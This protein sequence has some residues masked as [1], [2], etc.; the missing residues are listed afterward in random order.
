MKPL[1]WIIWG[2]HR[3]LTFLSDGAKRLGHILY[4]YRIVVVGLF[5]LF[6]V[7][8]LA[9][10]GQDLLLNLN[11]EW[12]GPI[13]FLVTLVVLASLNWHLPKYFTDQA[14]K[15]TQTRK[16][17]TRMFV[18][19]PEIAGQKH[20]GERNSARMMG[21][22]T[23]LIPAC[24]IWNAMQQ[25]RIKFIL[26]F[27]NPYLLLFVS[28]VIFA[29]AFRAQ[30]IGNLWQK[31]PRATSVLIT[32]ISFIFLFIIAALPFSAQLSAP[33]FLVFMVL[34]LYLLAI[35][36]SLFVA[37]RKHI[38]SGPIGWISR[39]IVTIVITLGI[40]F[41]V[42]FIVMNIAPMMMMHI[43]RYITFGV[44]LTGVIFYS[45]V[46]TM[47]ALLSRLWKINLILIMMVAG[48]VLQIS[49]NNNFHNIRMLTGNSRQP[50]SGLISK[51]SLP[52]LDS[53]LEGWLQHR[54]D[55]IL[56]WNA[57]NAR[58][59]R[60]EKYPVFLVN[61]YGGGIRAAAWTSMVIGY[62]DEV[63]RQNYGKAFQHHVLAYSAVSG[64]AIGAAMMCAQRYQYGD[65]QVMTADR[66]YSLY[67][68]DYLTPV[69]IGMQG[70]DIWFAPFRSD[71]I[72]DRA[73]FQE[74]TWERHLAL[75]S[76]TF[77]SSYFGMWYD[78]TATNAFEVPLLFSNTYNADDGKKG[79]LAPV[80]L[81]KNEFP[82]A[83][84][85]NDLY[86]LDGTDTIDENLR[87][88]TAAFLSAR[89]PYLSPT[90]RFSDGLHFLDGG[91]K[92]NSGAETSS[93]LFRAIQRI[94]Q[95]AKDTSQLIHK[96]AF[97]VLS[98]RNT[99]GNTEPDNKADN[100]SEITAP[101]TGLANNY[102][103]TSI[104]ADS[105]NFFE[106]KNRYHTVHPRRVPIKP[107]KGDTIRPILPLGWQI[108]NLALQGMRTSLAD[109]PESLPRILVGYLYCDPLKE[110]EYRRGLKRWPEKK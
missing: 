110:R 2:L 17:M 30:I 8:W 73:E 76:I 58:L 37:L 81:N 52:S 28:A 82:G 63:M 25:F 22:L 31:Y 48:F 32:V 94:M 26:D 69:L 36:F 86:D 108:S 84:F 62:M 79:I 33:K 5:I 14:R 72:A 90:A 47:I 97:H 11:T 98:I 53:Y 106:L 93:Q 59:G 105:V 43:S 7:L 10:Q 42:L 18:P 1:Q 55:S 50:S 65:A 70:R 34:D 40:I 41:S 57:R 6:I 74:R 44:V 54:R 87:I 68:R 101:L 77:N 23:F 38:H 109:Y 61:T 104:Q 99:F 16:G 19:P 95:N 66:I 100:I 12:Y 71:V 27:I 64:G 9:D 60:T 78:T 75:D 35:L 80:V 107:L 3:L 85:I 49:G 102:V 91:L 51:A 67:A 15:Q 46:F 4:N 89:F 45:F 39:N 83:N 13:S 20:R 103:G 96:V 24:G 88:S 92:E 56:A 21:V 29:T